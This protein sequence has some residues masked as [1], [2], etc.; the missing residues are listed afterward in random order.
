VTFAN[1]ANILNVLFGIGSLFSPFLY[2]FG[3]LAQAGLL[4][5]QSRI[6]ELEADRYGLH[7]ASEAGY[8]PDGALTFMRHLGA[9]H[10]EH[11]SFVDKYFEDHPGVPD[12]VS[13]L[14]GYPELDPKN[15]TIDQLLVQ[16]IHDQ[17]S[18]RYNIAAMK[19][20]DILKKDPGNT[21]AL[22][23]LGQ[24]Q[25]ALGQLTKGEQSL[26]EAAGKGNA[27]T[28][29]AAVMRIAALREQQN[30]FNPT[31]PK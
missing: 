22:L 13:H 27:E 9:L 2:R 11:A 14:V 31:K 1:K 3:Q 4:A 17:D 18:A 16:A 8:D 24:T 26:A 23:Y 10:D 30:R 21:I 19:F 5:K 15:R 28:K 6:D 12:R 25:L 7:L 20:T 29:A